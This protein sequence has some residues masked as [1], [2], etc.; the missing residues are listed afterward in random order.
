MAL[1]R[2]ATFVPDHAEHVMEQPPTAQVVTQV[3]MFK[4]AVA[5]LLLLLGALKARY[6]TWET[7]WIAHLVALFVS[8]VRLL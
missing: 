7:V 2:L 6:F 3:S 1:A 5:W 8:R 4:E